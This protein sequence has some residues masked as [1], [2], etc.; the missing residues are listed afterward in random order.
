MAEF[1]NFNSDNAKLYVSFFAL[2]IALNIMVTGL[3]AGRL[4]HARRRISKLLG[5]STTLLSGGHR[6]ITSA[7]AILIESAVPLAVMGLGAAIMEGLTSALLH[8][9]ELTSTLMIVDYFFS[10]MYSSFVVRG[11]SIDA[12]TSTDQS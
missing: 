11:L 9:P 3:I 4:I 12:V 6:D 2:S 7:T 5:H 10:L 8:R 1:K